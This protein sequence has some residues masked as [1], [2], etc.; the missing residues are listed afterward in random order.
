MKPRSVSDVK[1]R[2]SHPIIDCD[3]HW[4]ETRSILAEYV[5]EVADARVVDAYL[6]HERELDGGGSW[7]GA[8]DEERLA[9]RYRRQV[10]WKYPTKTR[11]YASFRLPGL[12]AERMEETGIDFGIVYPT[13][14]LMLE[15]Y[16][17]PDVRAGIVCGYNTMVADLF[18]PYADRLT[19]VAIVPRRSPDEALEALRHAVTDLGLKVVMINGTV[20][21]RSATGER[22]VDALGLDNEEDYDPLWQAC[23]DSGVAVTSHAGS[24]TWSNF[25]SVTNYVYN[26]VGH[27]AQANH[28]F[29]KAV[30]LGGVTRRFPTLNFAFLEGGAGW[31]RGLYCDLLGH[32][33]KRTL[34]AAKGF[35]N[36][37]DLDL[38]ELQSLFRKYAEP[39]LQ[40][41]LTGFMRDIDGEQGGALKAEFE[42]ETEHIND[43]AAAGVTTKAQ[44]A[45]A[46]AKNFY[47]GCEADDPM[48]VV[49]F[50]P[51]MG[52]PLKALFSSDIAHWDVPDI[53]EVLGEV[54]E[55]IDKDQ[56]GPD[57]FRDFTF[58]NAVRLHGGMNPAFFRGTT[59]ER[60]ASAVLAETAQRVAS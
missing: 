60:E 44:L 14:G 41:G 27:F 56:M 51:K 21:R 45:D 15:G 50:D 19:P 4:L 20:H 9:Q 18:R 52:R 49:A 7:Y 12:M 26:H 30:F 47:F 22:Y 6:Q 8:S 54:Y 38:D 28:T 57:Q 53:T 31:A 10:W 24:L 2:I 59:V 37:T 36:P 39:K 33:E 13:R 40:D 58:A 55:M 23:V 29:A 35:L 1:S 43:F 16:R 46:F 25:A 3:G 48:T 32:F 11:D 17:D 42:R 34:E 5:R